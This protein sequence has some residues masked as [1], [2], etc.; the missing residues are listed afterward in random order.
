MD[1]IVYKRV[2]HWYILAHDKLH[3]LLSSY[4]SYV[5]AD[6]MQLTS[7]KPD[8]FLDKI[9]L[10]LILCYFFSQIVNYYP[11]TIKILL[12]FAYLW[13]ILPHILDRPNYYVPFARLIF[14]FVFPIQKLR[15]VW[16]WHLVT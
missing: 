7:A 16:I 8:H 6:D 15:K 11:D 9:V 12:V 4:P 14:K 13:F 5:S 1:S 3:S 2:I 10:N